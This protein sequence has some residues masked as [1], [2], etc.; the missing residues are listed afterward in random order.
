[1]ARGLIANTAGTRLFTVVDD[2]LYSVSPA[3][4]RT[5]LGL[6]HTSRGTVGMKIGLTQ[7]VVVDGL[8]G[9]VYDLLSG[10]FT[11]IVSDGWLGS[12][13][14]EYLDGYFTFIDP[15]SQT[16][17]ISAL[18]DALT[19]DALDF[20]T[21]N[22]SPDKLVGQVVTNKVLVLLGEVSGEIWQDTGAADFPLERNSGAFLEV[23]L[24]ARHSVKELD[25]SAFWLGRD[26]RGAGFVYKM[27]GFRAVR[28]ST[29][30]VEET[31]QRAISE[32]NDVSQAVAYAYQQGG[33]SFY[34]LQV[35]G[36][37]TTWCYDAASQ[38]WHERAELVLGD[39]K[40][41]RGRFHAYCYGKHLITGDDDVIYE[42]DV[43][44]NTNAGDVLARDRVSPHYA[45]PQL[46]RIA[47]ARFE[48]DCTVGF[49][50]AGQSEAKAS[51]R[52]SNDGGYSWSDYRTATLGA[53]GEKQARARWLRLGSARDRIWQ[54]RVTDDV[55]FAII[56]VNIQ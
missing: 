36:L 6:L 49:G 52:Y 2:T 54:I 23:G 31:I 21:A 1:M 17:Y 22:A 27:E 3:G 38:F 55:P 12:Y 56:N 33:H 45:T 47:F 40:Q 50:K 18:E 39:Y 29:M 8:H 20:A 5:S 16:F 32:G 53:V 37:D 35:P 48:L 24:L 25:N 28:I 42:Y 9:Y 7:L 11:E 30:A 10:V 43:D 14:V 41:H 4:A 34:C 15:N 44:A 13:T 26:E 19:L 51:L 46:D